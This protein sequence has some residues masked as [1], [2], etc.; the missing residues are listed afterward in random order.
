MIKTSCKAWWLVACVVIAMV[1]VGAARGQDEL[2]TD[3]EWL[4]HYYEEELESF[5][6]SLGLTEAQREAATTLYKEWARRS[7]V[8]SKKLSAFYNSV[9][10]FEPGALPNRNE[11]YSD[12]ARKAQRH[13][14]RLRAEL[15][16]DL[17]TLLSEQQ[18]QQWPVFER[19]LRRRDWLGCAWLFTGGGIDL[20]NALDSVATRA[21]RDEQLESLLEDYKSAIDPSVQALERTQRAWMS[22]YWSQTSEQ[23]KSEAAM[24]PEEAEFAAACRNAQAVNLRW[25]RT[26]LEVA[27]DEQRQAIE[28]QLFRNSSYHTV[29]WEDRRRLPPERMHRAF[30]AKEL[31]VDQKAAIEETK[32]E[33]EQRLRNFQRRLFEACVAAEADMPDTEFRWSAPDRKT[34]ARV[35]VVLK[36][37]E[38]LVA[39]FVKEVRL[40][41]SEEQ[42]RGLGPPYV[43]AK[44]LELDLED[45]E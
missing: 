23:R 38:E 36:A 41:L 4:K 31:S 44:L 34:D 33:F 32:I 10:S 40:I 3:A 12:A 43:E 24:S 30:D 17:R 28:D 37:G 2:T 26:L 13:R 39:D 19:D 42:L 35:E 1:A 11:L 18:L 45:E 9:D 14:D 21:D 15:N 5:T 29:G 27:N 6:N 22:V 8:M 20:V 25:V 16:S 7:A